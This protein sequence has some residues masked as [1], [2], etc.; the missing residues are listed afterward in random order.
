VSDSVSSLGRSSVYETESDLTLSDSNPGEQ[1]GISDQSSPAVPPESSGTSPA[2]LRGAIDSISLNDLAGDSTRSA[3]SSSN[4]PSGSTPAYVPPGRRNLSSSTSA[5]VPPGRRNLTAPSRSNTPSSSST[6]AYVPPGRR[7]PTAP[8]GNNTPIRSNTPSSTPAYVPPSRRNAPSGAQGTAGNAQQPS[9]PPSGRGLRQ[10]SD[11][12]QAAQAES[13]NALVKN[14]FNALAQNADNMKKLFGYTGLSGA[15]TMAQVSREWNRQVNDKTVLPEL[16]GK[17]TIGE[18]EGK[19][20]L[21]TRHEQNIQRPDGKP[22]KRVFEQKSAT[23]ERIE[24]PHLTEG[25]PKPHLTDVALKRN[26]EHLNSGMWNGG[27]G[28]DFPTKHTLPVESDTRPGVPIGAKKLGQVESP[29]YQLNRQILVPVGD[30]YVNPKYIA[31]ARNNQVDPKHT[32]QLTDAEKNRTL[33]DVKRWE[34]QPITE[35]ERPAD[36]HVD[37]ES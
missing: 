28:A 12:P 8:S 33:N 1:T 37:R 14:G 35:S 22:G 16:Q 17:R 25:G 13:S 18:G 34:N 11:N 2:D 21:W 6:S 7:N 20:E 36:R 32:N 31:Q 24:F 23:G 9:A 15:A 19:T 29:T 10:F 30:K 5:Y 26:E 27:R 3:S 4:T